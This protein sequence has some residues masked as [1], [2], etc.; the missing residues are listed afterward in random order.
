MPHEVAAGELRLILLPPGRVDLAMSLDRH[1]IDVNLNAG[2]HRLAV[3]SDRLRDGEFPADSVSIWPKGTSVRI[4]AAN[5][6]PGCVL[7]VSETAMTSW[8]E[9]AEVD[10]GRMRFHDYRRDPTAAALGRAAI[11]HLLRDWRGQASADRLTVEALAL[12]IGARALARLAAGDDDAYAEPEGWRRHTGAARIVRAVDWAEAHLGDPTLAI[13][14]MAAAAHLSPSQF[15]SV[16]RAAT[17]ESPYAFVLRRRAERARDLILG[18]SDP[19]AQ[20]A[21]DAGFSSQSHMTATLG[22]LLGVTPGTLRRG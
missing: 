18:T 21:H 8:L 15:S 11:G 9:R 20:V 14:D 10:A 2:R 19:L 3:D 7:E 1:L 17:G 4:S 22:R 6:L 16:F 13:A 12:G 5:V